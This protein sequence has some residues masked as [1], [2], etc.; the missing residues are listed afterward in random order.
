MTGNG[1]GAAKDSTFTRMHVDC[2]TSGGSPISGGI[3][4]NLAYGDGNT[5][6]GGDIEGCDSMFSLGAER[7]QQ[8][9]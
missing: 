5:F 9:L 8:H 6:V 2:P 4:I 1:T 7:E 3:G